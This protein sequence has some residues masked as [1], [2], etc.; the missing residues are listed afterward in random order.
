MDGGELCDLSC[1]ETFL[2]T[3]IPQDAGVVHCY[4][5]RRKSGPFKSPEYRVFLRHGKN[6]LMG[7]KKNGSNNCYMITKTQ[8][9]SEL[10]QKDCVGR[11]GLVG[12]SLVVEW[13]SVVMMCVCVCTRKVRLA[14]NERIFVGMFIFMFYVHVMYGVCP[15]LRML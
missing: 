11:M 15:G 5:L 1:M 3:P 7:A 2:T 10:A 4:L 14:L 8:D 13:C 9:L 12:L 6:L